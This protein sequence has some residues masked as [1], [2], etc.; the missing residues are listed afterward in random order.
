TFDPNEP[1]ALHDRRW[2]DR[3]RNRAITDPYEPGS[4]F[5]AI[6]AA[7]AVEE[8]VVRPSDMFFCEN[9]RYRIGRWTVHDAHRHGW[10]SFAEVIQYSSNIGASKV[11]DRL[12]A[13]R[14][15]RYLRA[16]GFGA[17]TGVELPGESPGIMR[18]V[19][20]W[21]RIDLATHSFGQ[22]VSV[23]PAQM[24]AAFGAIANGGLLMRTYLV[25][26]VTDPIGRVTLENQP[27]P[28]RRVVSQRT[29]ATVTELL[30]RVVEEKG[31]TG[32][33]ARL[34]DF[35]VAG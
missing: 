18:P 22:G 16:F 20:S 17:R 10:L 14:Y 33:R 4:T 25:R 8:H 5:K 13:Q 34:D 3:V 9:G 29:A 26:R 12:G 35:P 7:A 27:T 28:L 31:G 15:Y 1:G 32:E 23:T 6:L 24:V 30:R 19:E 2:R 11:G 21:A